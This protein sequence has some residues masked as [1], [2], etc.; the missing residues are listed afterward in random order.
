MIAGAMG[1]A[2][3]APAGLVRCLTA[4]MASIKRHGR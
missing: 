2:M 3:M 4:V 1:V